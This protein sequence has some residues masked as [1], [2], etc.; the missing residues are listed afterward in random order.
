MAW[1]NDGKTLRGVPFC[2]RQAETPSEVFAESF[3][4]V[5][6]KLISENMVNMIK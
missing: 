2:R 5:I 1:K 6:I 3:F 4:Y